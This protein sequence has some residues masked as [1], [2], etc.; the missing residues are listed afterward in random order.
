VIL[1]K[2]ILLADQDDSACLGKLSYAAVET[3]PNMVLTLAEGIRSHA[4]YL[5]NLTS[6]YRSSIK[7]QV[8]KPFEAAGFRIERLIYIEPHAARL[9]AL[10][11]QVHS[12]ASLRPFMLEEAYWPTLARAAGERVAFHAAMKG[13]EIHGFVV[14]LQDGDTAVAWHIGFDRSTAG[15]GVPLYLRLLHASLSQAIEYGCRRVSFGRT[16][17]EPKARIGCLPETMQVWARHRQPML[18]QVIRPLLSFIQH[19][20][21][22]EY[23]PFKAG[24]KVSPPS[25]GQEA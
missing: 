17:L 9:Q 1:V 20:E 21:A 15:E 7:S 18:N 11:V 3:E 10:Y 8:F 13:E 12:N 16:A 23:S 4:D 5:A 19:A 25:G 6:K 22:P 2:D 14:T 24:D